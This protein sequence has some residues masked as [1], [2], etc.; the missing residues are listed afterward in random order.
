MS[1][2]IRQI[3]ASDTHWQ[4]LTTRL[5]VRKIK[6]FPHSP[7]SRFSNARERWHWSGKECGTIQEVAACEIHKLIALITPRAEGPFLNPYCRLCLAK[8]PQ[9]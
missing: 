9:S 5:L 1:L 3:T 2:S 4:F 8:L 6:K 7:R